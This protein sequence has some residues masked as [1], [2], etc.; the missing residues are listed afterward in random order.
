LGVDTDET[1]SAFSVERGNPQQLPSAV[2]LPAAI[3]PR[4]IYV[5]PSPGV[6]RSGASSRSRRLCCRFTPERL[7][8]PANS[9][10]VVTPLGGGKGKRTPAA[11]GN[12]DG[13]VVVPGTGERECCRLA[14]DSQGHD[15]KVGRRHRFSANPPS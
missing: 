8:W 9:L 11:R 7:P 15:G 3:R 14:Q 5:L 4:H 6:P 13:L 2:I 10:V 1:S 12:G